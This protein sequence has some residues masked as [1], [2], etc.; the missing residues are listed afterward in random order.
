[1]LSF[2]TTTWHLVATEEEDREGG[3]P[4]LCVG[5]NVWTKETVLRNNLQVNGKINNSVSIQGDRP[6]AFEG[7]GARDH[8]THMYPHMHTH[9]HTHR[10]KHKF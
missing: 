4:S 5:V 6:L 9:M 3:M 10:T 1:M 7:G 8:H 2:P